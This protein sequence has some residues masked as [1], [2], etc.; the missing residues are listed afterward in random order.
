MTSLMRSPY[1]NVIKKTD[2][3]TLCK[4]FV[5]IFYQVPIMMQAGGGDEQIAFDYSPYTLEKCIIHSE[6]HF[7][8]DSLNPADQKCTISSQYEGRSFSEL[9]SVTRYQDKLTFPS[10]EVQLISGHNVIEEEYLHTETY[11]TLQI[12][13]YLK[14]FME[15]SDYTNENNVVDNF[16]GYLRNIIWSSF[17]NKSKI[18]KSINDSNRDNLR[19]EKVVI[20]SR[21]E[22]KEAKTNLSMEVNNVEKNRS[23]ETMTGKYESV[24]D[25]LKKAYGILKKIKNDKTNHDFQVRKL[26]HDTDTIFEKFLQD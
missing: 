21:D 11:F 2:I 25:L 15:Q 3:K 16:D 26:C 10:S 17:M 20:Q 24:P 7:I 1:I 8:N 18:S 14:N 23:C 5:P 6:E 4:S 13:E 19:V 12:E 9:N 22:V